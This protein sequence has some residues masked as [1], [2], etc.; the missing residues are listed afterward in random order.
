MSAAERLAENADRE[1]A[2]ADSQILR[3]AGSNSDDW[4]DN[5]WAAWT[6]IV[7]RAHRGPR[8]VDEVARLKAELEAAKQEIS[9]LKAKLAARERQLDDMDAAVI[10]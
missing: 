1:A 3:A 5:T 10:A 4:D 2:D 9:E 7:D 6:R 8:P